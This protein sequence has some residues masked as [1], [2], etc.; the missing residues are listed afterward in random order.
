VTTPSVT[1]SVDMP[2]VALGVPGPQGPPGTGTGTGD[3]APGPMGP[4]GPTGPKGNTGNTGPQG[5]AGPQ[6]VPGQM[7]PAGPTGPQGLPGDVG[8][9]GSS[10]LLVDPN[11]PTGAQELWYDTDA[12][13]P[14]PAEVHNSYTAPGPAPGYWASCDLNF[15]N[16]AAGTDPEP[17]MVTAKVSNLV[18]R[19]FWIN[20]NGSPRGAS[21]QSEPALKLF[22]PATNSAYTGQVLQVLTR[23]DGTD[24][25]RHLFGIRGSDGLP[26][27]G[28]GQTVGAHVVVLATGAAVPAGL[29]AGT[30]IVRK[31]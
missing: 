10:P 18:K 29:P 14:P 5:P 19:S 8:P 17:F 24:S 12:V 13:A 1:I 21:I 23:W 15:P 30:V 27:V 22:G 16:L 20:E 25:Q 3:G 28:T 9:A 4:A 26:I 6:G 11:T 7:G 31:P 2:S